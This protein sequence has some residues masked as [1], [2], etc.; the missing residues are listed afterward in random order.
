MSETL[1]RIGKYEIERELGSGA[2]ATV[3]LAHDTMLHRQV[4]LKVLRP[5]LMADDDFV[6]RFQIDA[7]AAARLDHPH[8]ITIHDLGQLQGRLFIDMKYMPGGSLDGRLEAQGPLPAAEALRILEQVASALDYAHAQGLVHRDVKPANILFDAAGKAVLGDFGM[9]KSAEGSMVATLTLGGVVGTPAYMAPE[10][11]EEADVTPA[12]DVYALGCVLYDMLIGEAL[13]QGSTL[14]SVMSAHLR[15]RRFPQHWPAGVPPQMQAALA[16]AVAQEPAQRFAS[17]GSFVQALKAPEDPLSGLYAQ[18]QEAL[19]AQA[20]AQALELA[21]EINA[22]HK[23]YRDVTQLIAQA[24]AQQAQEAAQEWRA[25]ALQAETAGDAT[26]ART[27]L[28][29][30]LQLTPQDAEALA[31]QQRLAGLDGSKTLVQDRTPEQN[32]EPH[33]PRI[34]AWL[35]LGAIVVVGGILSAVFLLVGALVLPRDNPIGAT[36]TPEKLLAADATTALETATPPAPATDGTQAAVVAQLQATGTAGALGTAT[37][38][39]ETR[40]A[41]DARAT[42]MGQVGATATAQAQATATAQARATSIPVAALVAELRAYEN[43]A[44]LE[45]PLAG[46]LEHDSAD[47]QIETYVLD[48]SLSDFV[49]SVT[50]ENPYSPSTGPWA[51]GVVFRGTEFNEQYRLILSSDGMLRLRLHE[52]SPSSV[53]RQ[54][55]VIPEAAQFAQLGGR[56]N[57]LL[58]AVDGPVGHVLVNDVYVTA[59]DLS[60]KTERGRISVATGFFTG[61]EIDDNRTSFSNLRLWRVGG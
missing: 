38:Y 60:Q 32:T 58:L 50:F 26:V 3:F 19:A 57:H 40:A 61:Y 24:R 7:R 41:L 20:W 4:A 9:V 44:P 59:L 21:E 15:P 47:D 28:K 25:L 46:E 42:A 8:I 31:L 18:L 14:P 37:R 54:D 1:G 55:F 36:R 33:R 22:R 43:R 6:A 30:W 11:W 17:A 29:R 34:L 52:G 51:Y 45:G 2:F 5:A 49:L 23:G 10:L 35:M 56:E 39:A 16:R 13:F 53:S 12:T 48:S 27:A